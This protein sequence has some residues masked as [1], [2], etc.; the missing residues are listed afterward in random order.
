MKRIST[1]LIIVFITSATAWAQENM[2]TITGGYAWA[3]LEESD[4]KPTG[5]R[6]NGIYE[7]NPSEG[8]FSHGLSIGYIGTKSDSAGVSGVEYKLNN[9]PIYYAPKI[10]FGKGDKIKAFARGALGMHFSGYKRTTELL[11]I[12]TNDTGFYGGIAVG[13]MVFVKENVFLNAEYE[14]AYLSNSFY[15]NGFM[16]S[17]NFG[18]GFRF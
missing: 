8:N 14:W 17:A 10:M 16:N 15:Q 7:F 18:L 2:L 4:T 12:S 13:L 1:I 5:F 3:S 6:I 9:W 11:T